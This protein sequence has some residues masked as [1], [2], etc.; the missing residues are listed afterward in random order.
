MKILES[1]EIDTINITS[2][3]LLGISGNNNLGRKEFILYM[4]ETLLENK[5]KA[6]VNIYIFD[7]E[8]QELKE[9]EN[10]VQFYST[11]AD[12]IK[13]RLELLY[14][15][16]DKRKG[17]KMDEKPLE[18]IV[19]NNEAVYELIGKEEKILENCKK[20]LIECSE[21][22]FTFALTKVDNISLQFKAS[23]FVKLL[24]DASNLFIFNQVQNIKL[25]DPG[26]KTKSKYTK[27][28][29]EHEMYFKCGSYFGKYKIPYRD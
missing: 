17:K 21:C 23:P 6:P 11:D 13:E 28:L 14:Q 20:C 7:D 9:L 27:P 16:L 5:Q 2:I 19:I 4:I 1:M 8:E 26:A 25:F 12:A 18:Y 10:A 15:E 29:S 22:K 3:Q 24:K